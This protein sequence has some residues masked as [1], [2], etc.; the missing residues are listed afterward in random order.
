MRRPIIIFFTAIVLAILFVVLCTF[1]RRPYEKVLL[2]RFGKLVTEDNQARILSNYNWYLKY[3]TDSVVRVDTRL[4]LFYT[5]LQQITTSGSQSIS[6]RTYA[7][8]RIVDPV[9][10]YTTTGTDERLNNFLGNALSSAVGQTISRHHMDDMFNTDPTKLK[11]HEMEQKIQLEATEGNK[12]RNLKG[13]RELGVEIVQ[14]GFSRMAF[15]PNNADA[16]YRRMAEEQSAKATAFLAEGRAEHDK[17][18]SDGKRQ[19]SEITAE[20]NREAEK[21]R[22]EADAQATAAL[23]VVQQSQAA[24][25]F[26][27]FWKSLDFIKASFTKNTY[28]VLP[29]D[30]DILR[31]LFTAPQNV[32]TEFKKPEASSQKN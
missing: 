7:V 22:G 25:D 23:A 4:H 28:L 3:P 20:A 21:I 15:A 31:A 12:A 13:M 17:L 8:W 27:Q 16:I 32:Q 9:L 24:R 19:A 10:F 29:T 14:V 18:V 5:P 1:V 11:T 2:Y 6:V 30:S 26:Y